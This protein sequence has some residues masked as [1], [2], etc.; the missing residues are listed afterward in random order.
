[1]TVHLDDCTLLRRLIKLT[2]IITSRPVIAPAVLLD[3][4]EIEGDIRTA[5]R[6]PASGHHVGVVEGIVFAVLKHLAG[7]HIKTMG[8]VIR[9]ATIAQQMLP[10][11]RD[12]LFEA[13]IATRGGAHHGFHESQG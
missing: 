3:L 1:V 7:G 9:F 13:V 5:I 10:L 11:V 12:H 8:E 6:C 2:E 4:C